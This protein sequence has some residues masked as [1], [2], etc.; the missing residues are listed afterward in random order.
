[1]TTLNVSPLADVRSMILANQNKIMD[2]I[3]QSHYRLSEI[4]KENYLT[5]LLRLQSL[6]LNM[7]SKPQKKCDTSIQKSDKIVS[8]NKNIFPQKR[9]FPFDVKKLLEAVYE[10]KPFPN[11]DEKQ[12]LA[13]KTNLSKR[14][15]EIWFTNK[16]GRTK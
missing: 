11:F 12:A 1:S 8:V 2:Y 16:R 13:L 7:N 14:Q 15:I 9:E 10:M 5:L 6:F 3:L 4:F